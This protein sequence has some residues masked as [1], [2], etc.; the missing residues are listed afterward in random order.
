MLG[1]GIS[2]RV[3]LVVGVGQ[4]SLLTVLAAKACYRDDFEKNR[5]KSKKEKVQAVARKCYELSLGALKDPKN[6]YRLY[7]AF[8]IA[9]YSA[10]VLDSALVVEFCYRQATRS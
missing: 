10:L 9:F 8:T 2:Q 6:S 1:E 5:T 3:G 4:L 7:P